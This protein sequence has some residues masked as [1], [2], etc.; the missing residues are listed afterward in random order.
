MRERNYDTDYIWR[1][2][3]RYNRDTIRDPFIGARQR[4]WIKTAK[5]W[6]GHPKKFIKESGALVYTLLFKSTLKVTY[7]NRLIIYTHWDEPDIIRIPDIL[8]NKIQFNRSDMDYSCVIMDK[9]RNFLYIFEFL[10]K[11]SLWEFYEA[12]V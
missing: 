8:L 2:R 4:L 9:Y 6:G 10:L 11:H 1:E 7:I 5:Q 3:H 12:L